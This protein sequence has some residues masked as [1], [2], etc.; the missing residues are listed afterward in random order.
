M[1][2][3]RGNARKRKPKILWAAHCL[4]RNCPWGTEST[5]LDTVMRA[6]E[7]HRSDSNELEIKK[8]SVMPQVPVVGGTIPDG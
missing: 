6:V 1:S 4:S 2:I 7:A 5:D 8:N 3:V